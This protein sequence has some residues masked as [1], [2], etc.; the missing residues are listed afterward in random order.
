M[1]IFKIKQNVVV[2]E[3]S[4]TIANKVRYAVERC[5]VGIGAISIT[6]DDFYSK[7]RIDKD[8]FGDFK[9]A[10]DETSE[11]K[12]PRFPPFHTIDE[13][14]TLSLQLQLTQ[15]GKNTNNFTEMENNRV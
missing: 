15:N 5:S 9:L 2:L 13:A 10:V 3:S 4:R 8:F 6:S 7:R 12:E 1:P 11:R 14:I